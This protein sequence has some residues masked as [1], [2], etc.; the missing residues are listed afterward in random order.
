MIDNVNKLVSYALIN[1]YLLL[2]KIVLYIDLINYN[3][4]IGYGMDKKAIN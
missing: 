2:I 4:Y 3:R 1:Y